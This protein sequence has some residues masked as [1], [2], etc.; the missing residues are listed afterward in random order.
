MG[1]LRDA[2]RRL[3]AP[4]KQL[5]RSALPVPPA[6]PAEPAQPA[7]EDKTRTYVAA[8]AAPTHSIHNLGPLSALWLRETIAAY[9]NGSEAQQNATSVAVFNEVSKYPGGAGDILTPYVKARYGKHPLYRQIAAAH[10][11]GTGDHRAAFDALQA[12]AIDRKTPFDAAMAAWPL[13]RPAGREREALDY[14]DRQCE[15]FPDDLVLRVH[16]ATALYCT[17]Q[18]ARATDEITRIKDGLDAV[19]S[20]GY[21]QHLVE[22]RAELD[23]ALRDKTIYR[24]FNFDETSYRE[25]LI[26]N[27]WEPY[28]HWMTTQ[29]EHVMFGWLNR[30]FANKLADLGSGID[31]VYNFGVMCAQPDS[32]AAT[33]LPGTKFIGVD[34]QRT[35][36]ALNKLAYPLPNMTFFGDEIENV[37]A[38][39]AIGPTRSLFHARTT[40]LCYPEKVRQLYRTCAAKGFRRIG[41]FENIALSH[42]SYR[43]YDMGGDIENA[44]TIYKSDQFIHD[45]RVLLE[46]A[47]YRITKEER[48]FSPLITPFSEIDLG[49]VHVYLEAELNS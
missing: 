8:G 25:D 48:M 32:E 17:R 38:R 36:A 11:L 16:L 15:I 6:T 18:T 10:M 13:M 39:L 29:S 40:T 23:K 34:R 14:L 35:T 42:D 12:L 21:G 3:P 45:Y 19:L 43:F 41:L 49:S 9:S 1:M 33:K 26:D 37:L 4:V 2:A 5:I 28:F 44:S 20:D 27:H 46:E 22:L 24:R 47:G 7:K 30:F 31:E